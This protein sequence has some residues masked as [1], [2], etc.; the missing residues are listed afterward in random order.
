MNLRISPS[1]VGNT[2]EF[3]EKTWKSHAPNQCFAYDFL[4]DKID[5]FYKAER[6]IKAVL[7]MFSLLALL[8]AAFS[9]TIA[10]LSVAY[11]AFQAA[12]ANPVDSLKYE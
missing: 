6:N 5:G 2:L 11:K 3:L 4:D 10:F 9:M 7:G 8:A 1:N 12:R